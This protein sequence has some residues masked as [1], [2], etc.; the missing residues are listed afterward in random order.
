MYRDHLDNVRSRTSGGK[1]VDY[2][3]FY[4]ASADEAHDECLDWLKTR[5]GP[6][7]V[8]ATSMP[9][10]AYM[11]NGL[12]AVSPPAESTAERAQALLDSVPVTY[13]V[14]SPKIDGHVSNDYVFPF[15]DGNPRAWKVVY[16]DQK[17]LS[18]VFQRVRSDDRDAQ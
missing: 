13:V 9:Q 10:W 5:A 3:V 8:V 4:Y 14:L 17:G 1:P 15:V 12:K 2:R 18:R 6:E 7:D 11:R 16:A